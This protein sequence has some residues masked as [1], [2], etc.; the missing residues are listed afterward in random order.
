MRRYVPLGRNVE[1]FL[2]DF[3][4]IWTGRT[5]FILNLQVPDLMKTRSAIQ[6]KKLNDLVGAVRIKFR[7]FAEF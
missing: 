4:Q 5:N 2:S 3:N 1:L 6:T 7:E